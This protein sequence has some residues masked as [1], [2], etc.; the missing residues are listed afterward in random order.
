MEK[1]IVGID[2][3]PASRAG[4]DWCAQHADADTE[5]IAV[6]GLSELGEFVVS[7]P[8]LDTSSPEQI[9]REFEERWCAPLAAAGVKWRAE[10]LHHAQGAALAE[11]IEAEQPTL[12]V[13]GRPDHV[14]VDLMLHGKLQHALHH[15]RCPIVLVPAPSG[16]SAQP[17]V[18][19]SE[20]R[21]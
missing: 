3:S 14:T 10:F 2:G 15:A 11:V 6:C 16:D 9:R 1:V 13:M 5:V 20:R 12:V 4:V 19:A 7:L 21:A 17:A 8:G 18:A